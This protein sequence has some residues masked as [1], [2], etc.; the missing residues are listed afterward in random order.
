VGATAHLP[1]QALFLDLA[2]KLAKRLF[3]VLRILDDYLQEL[4]TSFSRL[5]T[6][7]PRT[8]AEPGTGPP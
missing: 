6:P 7:R 8:I 4:I 2:A 5:T 1:Y 3:E